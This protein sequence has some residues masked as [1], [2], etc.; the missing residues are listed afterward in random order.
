MANNIQFKRGLKENLPTSAPSGTPL[1]CTDTEELY[2]GTGE[3]IAMVSTG[4]SYSKDEIDSLIG[5]IE[6]VLSEV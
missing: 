4:N 5:N 2:I 1:W 3:S 6:N